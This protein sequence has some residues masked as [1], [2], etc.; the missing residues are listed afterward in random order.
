MKRYL[1]LV[2]STGALFSV[3]LTG[4]IVPTAHNKDDQTLVTTA[5]GDPDNLR[6][7]YENW[8]K[9]V[10]SD[11]SQ[12]RFILRSPQ[13][14]SQQAM[15]GEVQ[16]RLKDGILSA[17]IPESLVG[18][19]AL[20]L[21]RE[22]AQLYKPGADADVGTVAMGSFKEDGTL[23]VSVQALLDSGF[24]FEQLIV[25][26][27]GVNPLASPALVGS[28]SLF[29][30]LLAAEHA[31][32]GAEGSLIPVAHAGIPSLFPSVFNDLVT[33]GE[34]LFFL[35]AFE[36]NGRSCG[37]CHEATNNFTIDVP[38]MESLA[39]D[40]PLFVAE[41]VPPL[42]FGHPENL[43]EN[44][45]PRR[46]EN[47]ALMRAFG[48][49]VENLDGMDDLENRFTMRGVPHNIGMTVSVDNPPQALSPPEQRT[50]WSGD[51]APSGV[52][53]GIAA[54]GRVRD[55]ILGAIVQHYPK[56]MARSFDGP[57]P[58]FRVPTPQ[59]LDALEAFMFSVG[60]QA[61]LELNDG[62]PNSLSLADPDAEAGKVLF[63]DGIPP[64]S[65]TCNSCHAQAGANILAGD[66]P[67]NRNFN[68]GVELFLRNRM[69]DPAFTVVGEPRPV[70][71]GFGL[72]PNGD[73]TALTPQ[74]GFVNENFGN[75]QFN[76]V[77]V[78]EAADTAP[79]FHNNIAATVEDSIRFYNSPEFTQSFFNL[80][81]PFDDDQV[82]KVAKFM[83]AINAL[84]NIE[85]SSI[86]H[87]NRAL[88]AL[89]QNSVND[90]VVN[91]ILDIAIAD[92][93]DAF[94]VLEE[95]ELHNTGPLARNAVKKLFRAIGLLSGARA[96]ACGPLPLVA[97]EVGFL[98]KGQSARWRLNVTD[99]AEQPVIVI[100]SD[101]G[102]GGSQEIEIT[103]EGTSR[104]QALVP[105]AT[106]EIPWIQSFPGER[107]L[108]IKTLTSGLWIKSVS[109][110]YIDAEVKGGSTCVGGPIARRVRRV[111]KALSHL[112]ATIDII[113]N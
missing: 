15:I 18:S 34:D 107:V 86:R 61:E 109:M 92:A 82:A 85:N 89:G 90:P 57:N 58:D 71:G 47:P 66:N 91:R 38:F 37:T 6:T 103:Y 51:G 113:R 35:E 9:T 45:R 25:A 99:E 40:D 74:P 62:L 46:F 64:G 32:A 108:E 96:T 101:E 73:F 39:D 105:G 29:Q 13:I 28:A 98:A 111:N 22:G 54:S 48:L 17:H 97:E 84:D 65:F 49:I 93:E 10:G 70:D 102:P 31:Q 100:E 59:E 43:D 87:A 104:V 24:E 63:R 53:G 67:G 76:T 41:F 30:R 42:I 68:T 75:M 26:K 95:G 81:I 60:R 77:S 8:K 19:Y 78:V 1:R 79:F 69:N 56:T 23:S 106:L 83:R 7:Q 112:Q 3:A 20:Y 88:I 44:G 50:G 55:F 21:T 27:E 11:P 72:N 4:L 5:V 52:V 12:L 110:K 94:Q 16:V 33:Q 14:H 80:A 36:G 2:L